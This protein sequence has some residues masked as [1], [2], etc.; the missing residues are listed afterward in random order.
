MKGCAMAAAAM[1]VLAG[2]AAAPRRHSQA[3]DLAAIES[4]NQRYLEAINDG[5]AATLNALTPDDHLMMMP[6][7]PVV[8]GRDRLE[9]A[10]RRMVEQFSIHETWQPVE[11]VIDGGLAYQRGTFSTTATPK[12]GGSART[13][14]GK[15]L[16]IYRRLADGSWTMVID[17]FSADRPPPPP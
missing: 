17:S 4:Y 8:S 12:G 5:D 6:N 13:S 9:A 11:T 3:A 7:Q 14:D 15:F 16:R 10:N 1:L 2:C